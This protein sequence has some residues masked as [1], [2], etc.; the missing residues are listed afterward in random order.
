MESPACES[1][2]RWIVRM[3]RLAFEFPWHPIRAL[4]GHLTEG[5]R[6]NLNAEHLV[7]DLDTTSFPAFQGVTYPPCFSK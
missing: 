2:I 7:I 4:V 1:N 6:E 5:I 3:W